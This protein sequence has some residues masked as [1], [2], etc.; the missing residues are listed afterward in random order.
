MS[1]IV[2]IK[3]T[4]EMIEYNVYTWE[5]RKYYLLSTFTYLLKQNIQFDARYTYGVLTFSKRSI[6][7]E[8]IKQLNP[9]L[10]RA[11]IE[12]HWSFKQVKK[13]LVCL[14]A[15]RTIHNSNQAHI[16]WERHC[17]SYHRLL[18]LGNFPPWSKRRVANDSFFFLWN[19]TFYMDQTYFTYEF[20][21][22]HLF[23]HYNSL[24]S[25]Q[26]RKEHK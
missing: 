8:Q 15:S 13:P 5:G 11:V 1:W 4:L 2:M 24:K 17:F 26:V 14:K 20:W 7:G 10:Q 12:C 16:E 21:R 6:H 23:Y 9:R 22:L 25:I 3:S 19:I 18:L